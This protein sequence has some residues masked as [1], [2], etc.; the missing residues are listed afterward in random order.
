[1]IELGFQVA[2]RHGRRVWPTATW[3][4]KQI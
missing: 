4:G 1:M 2:S 3:A